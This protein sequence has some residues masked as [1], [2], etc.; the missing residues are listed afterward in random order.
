VTS[1]RKVAEVN[2]EET[3]EMVKIPQTG[4]GSSAQTLEL[5]VP[6]TARIPDGA[7]FYEGQDDGR[8]RLI[9]QDGTRCRGARGKATGLCP[10]HAGLSADIRQYSALGHE[11][12]RK[13]A[14]A[15][16]TLGITTRRAASPL[17]A[18]RVA[19]QIRADD[20]ARALVDDPLDDPELGSVA[21]QQAAVR[22]LELLYPQVQ[23]RVEVELPA[24]AGE[25]QGMGWQ[26]MQELAARLVT[27]SDQ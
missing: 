16:A 7:T 2:P 4:E 8:C 10:G 14:R 19:A 26:E 23:A 6:D 5:H 13:Q 22:A 24:E 25:V 15:R 3:G 11:A 18:A 17:Q 12:R 21:R 9:K 27:S 1:Q 20:Y